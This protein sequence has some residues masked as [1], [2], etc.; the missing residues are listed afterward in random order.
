ME[1]AILKSTVVQTS[2]TLEKWKFKES[3]VKVFM[4]IK[5]QFKTNFLGKK[6][7]WISFFQ[8]TSKRKYNHK[9][10]SQVFNSSM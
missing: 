2:S 3:F 7:K 4:S 10:E 8:E 6:T 5:L 1:H 9:R